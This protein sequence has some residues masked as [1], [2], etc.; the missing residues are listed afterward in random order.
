MDPSTRTWTPSCTTGRWRWWSTPSGTPTGYH[1]LSE[2][3]FDTKLTV[4]AGMVALAAN[5]I[6]AIAATFVLRAMNVADGRDET[7]LRDYFADRG[8]PR[9]HDLPAGEEPQPVAST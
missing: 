4:W 3:G 5:L 7:T 8:D 6:V 9:V 2:L 1:K